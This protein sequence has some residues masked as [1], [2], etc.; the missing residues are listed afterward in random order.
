MPVLFRTGTMQID[1]GQ[2]VEVFRQMIQPA[3]FFCGVRAGVLTAVQ[4]AGNSV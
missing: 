4:S 1:T 3:Q 2:S